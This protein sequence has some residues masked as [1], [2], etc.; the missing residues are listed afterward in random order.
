MLKFNKV[1]IVLATALSIV[2]A[3]A[4]YTYSSNEINKIVLALI[5]FTYTIITLIGLIAI[6]FE[7]D[8][9]TTLIKTIS[10]S[11]L[12]IGLVVFSLI[13]I[14]WYHLPTL[15]ILFS[16]LILLYV[17]IGYGIAKSKH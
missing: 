17:A 2:I 8:K 5:S 13:G 10:G 7:Y 14:V 15:I 9:T 3:Y 16:L 12:L 4:F 6:K 1:T 11:F